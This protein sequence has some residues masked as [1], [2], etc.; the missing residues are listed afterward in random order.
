[1]SGDGAKSEFL[2]AVAQSMAAETFVRLTLGKYRG[3]GDAEKV[4][5]TPVTIKGDVLLKFVTSRA[6]QDVTKNYPA[7][8]ALE[9][10]SDI[11]GEKFLAATLFS[12]EGDVALQFSKKREA[13]LVRGK[14]TFTARPD[15]GHDRAKDYHVD[16]AAA[17]LA[18][19]GISDAK[20]IVKPSMFAKFKQ[21]NHFI[22]I[23]DDLLRE[24]DLAAGNSVRVADIGSG[25]GYLTFALFDYLRGRIGA[26]LTVAGI[27]VRDD[28]VAFCNRVAEAQGFSGLSFVARPA[29]EGLEGSVDIL[30][31]LH[32]CDTATDDAIYEGI[33]AGAALIVTAP[34]CQ[35]ELAPQIKAKGDLEGLLKFGLFKQ[36]EADLLTDAARCLLLEAAGYQVKVIEFV[37]TEHT[38]KNVMLAAVRS[39]RVDRAAARREYQALKTFA[40]FET[41]HLERRLGE[42]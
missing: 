24:T 13:R 42:R 38:A 37:S 32:A 25:K 34:C 27:E 26:G 22:E 2:A 30:I 36:R 16:P 21:I 3:P 20:G 15:T 10:I 4:V 40:G 19:L 12:T 17:Y 39:A 5:V 31:A 35:H 8:A 7:K 1:M 11:V 33:S 14:A 28:L 41:Q 29:S 9:E 18:A 23:I 6:R